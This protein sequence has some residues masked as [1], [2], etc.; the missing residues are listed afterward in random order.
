[1]Y[2]NY[3]KAYPGEHATVQFFQSINSH[4]Y[5]KKMF[6]SF[7]QSNADFLIKYAN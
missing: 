6:V 7:S 4:F 2:C 3:I 5:I 1:M